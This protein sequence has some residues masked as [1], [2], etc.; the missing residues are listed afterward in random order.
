MSQTHAK[1]YISGF[2]LNVNSFKLKQVQYNNRNLP[3]KSFGTMTP[4]L[5]IEQTLYLGERDAG[6]QEYNFGIKPTPAGVSHKGLPALQEIF[7]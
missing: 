3:I 2:G 4:Q 7:Q 5:S 6:S 1:G